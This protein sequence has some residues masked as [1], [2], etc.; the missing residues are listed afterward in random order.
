MDETVDKLRVQENK[1]D[2]ILIW[3][4]IFQE[5]LLETVIAPRGLQHSA[6]EP[7]IA[8][9][10]ANGKGVDIFRRSENKNCSLSFPWSCRLATPFHILDGGFYA[11]NIL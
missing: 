7:F 9:L 1:S 8:G 11:E 6:L 5:K 3:K 10:P 4:A 2:V